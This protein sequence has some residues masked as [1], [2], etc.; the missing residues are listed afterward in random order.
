MVLHLLLYIVFPENYGYFAHDIRRSVRE[1]ALSK[2]LSNTESPQDDSSDDGSEHFFIPLSSG[3]LRKDVGA[4]GNRRKQKIVISSSQT[5][6]PKSTS[7]QYFNSDSPI[8]TT[9]ALSSKRNGHGDSSS[10]GNF[11]DPLSSSQSFMTDDA[12]DQLF[13]P[14]LLLESSLFHDA[15]EDLLGKSFQTS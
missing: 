15:Y 1:A 8:H 6:L 14:P 2:P 12:L 9:S 11:F 4:V 10:A 7:D 13:S 3:T 5:K